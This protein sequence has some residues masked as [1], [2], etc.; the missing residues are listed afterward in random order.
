MPKNV[1][2]LLKPSPHRARNDF[3]LSHRHVF[4][5]NFGELLPATCIETVPGDN[6]TLHASDL[7]R[8]IP[9]VSSPFLRA[10]QH[11]DVWF[12]PYH[13]L[14]HQFD[15]FI[16]KKSEPVSAAFKKADYCPHMSQYDLYNAIHT[17]ASAPNSFTD[18]HGRSI[19]DRSYY[20]LELLG[21]GDVKEHHGTSSDSFSVNP[22]RL[23]AYNYI[24]Y[25]EYRQQYYDDGTRLLVN[26][27]STPNAAQLFNFDDLTCD[28]VANSVV[29]DTSNFKQRL[30]AMSQM[31]YRCWKKDLFTGVM[32]STQ[33]GNV[34]TVPLNLSTS[35]SGTG[36]ISGESFNLSFVPNERYVTQDGQRLGFT[37]LDNPIGTVT[38][39]NDDANYSYDNGGVTMY[40]DS[41]YVDYQGNALDGSDGDGPIYSGSGSAN[42]Y[43]PNLAD[44][45]LSNERIS[46]RHILNY[47]EIAS[48]L[49]VTGSGTSTVSGI[50]LSSTGQFDILALRKSEAIQIWRENALRAGNHIKDNMIAH[51]GVASDFNDHR[52]TYLGSV[53]APLNIG[54]IAATANSS[55]GINDTVGDIAGKGISSLSEKVF[56]YHAKDFGV[57]MVMFSMLPEAEY[58]A[59]GIDRCNQLL[60]SEDFFVPEYENLGLEAVSTVNIAPRSTGA[61]SLS[62]VLGYGPRYFG[63]KTK[64]DKVFGSFVGNGI[65]RAWSSQRTD[66]A[67]QIGNMSALAMPLGILYVNPGIFDA[68]FNVG[69]ANS[70][71]FLCDVY[72]DVAA[73]R[74]MSVIGLPFS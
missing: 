40:A 44:G 11:L 21:Y 57:I 38:S 53:S 18:I 50:S 12:V 42:S 16:T 1:M 26:T 6:I 35:G 52:P 49:A 27:G 70:P 36:T 56:K 3:D 15:A 68:N 60:E 47:S 8:A 31:R 34:S 7:L 65:F 69:I 5:A 28:S 41:A 13:D 64:I 59:T 45:N 33:F 71:Q 67:T 43:K 61:P 46:H 54:D 30:A 74:P 19:E 23:A 73:I 4:D 62:T 66:V 25:N 63:Y 22:F 10:K 58:D 20:L 51:Y 37:G 17:G 32:P 9:F 39:H 2:K 14:W 29:H 55:T 24:W 72:F 48:R